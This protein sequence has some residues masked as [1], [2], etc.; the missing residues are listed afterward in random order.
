VDVLIVAG[1]LCLMFTGVV[2][3]LLGAGGAILG[4]PIL[5]FLLGVS[6]VAATGYSL[7]LVGATALVGAFQYIRRGYGHPRMAV[8]YGVPAIVGVYLSRRV[9]F[10]AVPD[11]VF[12]TGSFVVSKDTMVMVIFAIFMLTAARKMITSARQ[13]DTDEYRPHRYVPTWVI[14]ILGTL[15]GVL[16]G[17]VGAGGGFMILPVLVLMGGLPMR[18]AIGTSLLVI[19]AQSLVGFVG[20]IQAR[21]SIDYVFVAS[22]LVPPFFGIFLGTWLNRKVRA[23]GLKTAFGWFLLV[24]GV[25][26]VGHEMWIMR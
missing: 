5:V 11:P 1:Y 20:E 15:V 4:V 21:E 13:D 25:V 9:V 26:I 12:T 24:V 14:A 16:T 18:M 7:V 10:P 6:P 19:A 22:I 17:F 23:T 3:G 8:L 2:L